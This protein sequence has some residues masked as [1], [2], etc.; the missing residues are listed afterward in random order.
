VALPPRA[1]LSVQ[2]VE[3][4]EAATLDARDGG[5]RHDT[6]RIVFD[7][8]VMLGKPIVRGTRITV[9]HIVELMAQG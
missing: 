5:T 9:E 4:R 2:L 7:P 6:P 1:L 3:G 8:E